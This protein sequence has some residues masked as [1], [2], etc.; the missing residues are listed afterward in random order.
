MMRFLPGAVALVVLGCTLEPPFDRTNPFDP[1]SPYEMQLLGVPDTV[2]ARGARFTAVIERDPPLPAGDLSI[3]WEAIDPRFGGGFHDPPTPS[4]YVLPLAGGEFVAS[5][6]L[7]A[8]FVP[9]T[10]AARFNSSVV[11]GRTIVVGQRARTLSL[12]CSGVA[13][14]AV[15]TLVGQTRAIQSTA[16]DANGHLLAGLQHAMQRA[17]VI[18]RDPSVIAP[19]VTPNAGGLYG[20]S[21]VGEGNTWV[22]ITVDLATDSVRFVVTPPP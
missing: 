5:G 9:A 15:P 17:T 12:S 20:V 7:T 22:V 3:K 21:A 14:D 1:G 4:E 11:V 10:I 19:S 8:E 18:S 2:D 6:V 16:T 13:C